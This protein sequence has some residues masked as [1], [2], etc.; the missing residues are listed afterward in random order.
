MGLICI[1]NGNIICFL[2]FILNGS[3]ILMIFYDSFMISN[4]DVFLNQNSI[5]HKE[6]E[7]TESSSESE[8]KLARRSKIIKSQLRV[9]YEI[10]K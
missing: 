2:E 6:F 1:E 7:A 4:Y 9:H 5:L 3:H 10:S 8:M